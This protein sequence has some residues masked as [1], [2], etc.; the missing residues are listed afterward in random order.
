[1]MLDSKIRSVACKPASPVD[2]PACK[3]E[4]RLN[5]RRLE[6]SEGGP[7]GARAREREGFGGQRW[8]AAGPGDAAEE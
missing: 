5:A 3:R 6:E 8:A 2:S 1:M 4:S 7:V